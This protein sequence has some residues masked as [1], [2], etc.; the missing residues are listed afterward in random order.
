MKPQQFRRV[1]VS[2]PLTDGHPLARHPARLNATIDPPVLSGVEVMRHG[3][4]EPFLHAHPSL[5]SASVRWAG[6]ALE[7]YSVPACII[8]RHEHLENFLHV[9]LHGSVKYE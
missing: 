7:D 4:V 8:Q 5:S 1:N 2:S 6:V 3:H 9:V